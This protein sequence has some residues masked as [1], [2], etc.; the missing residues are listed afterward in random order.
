MCGCLVI[1]FKFHILCYLN[2]WALNENRGMYKFNVFVYIRMCIC[3][4]VCGIVA[5]IQKIYAAFW[6]LC[7]FCIFLDL[8]VLGFLITNNLH[9]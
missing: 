8:F 3:I 7:L 9:A 6:Y 2:F 4:S 1:S 5:M